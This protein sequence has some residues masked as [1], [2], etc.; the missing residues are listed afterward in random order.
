[1]SGGHYNYMQFHINTIAEQIKKDVED[2][3][4]E[5]PYTFARDYTKA[6][7]R[8]LLFLADLLTVA[9]DLTK[10]ADWLYSGD[11]SEETFNKHF[12]ARFD[13]LRKLA[14]RGYENYHV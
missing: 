3:S 6:T 14:A 2:H 9:S 10:D 5:E 4:K 1:M 7:L 13:F 11:D 12:D 8:K